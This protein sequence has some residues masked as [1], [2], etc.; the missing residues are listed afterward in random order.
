MKVYSYLRNYLTF[1]DYELCLEKL[2]LLRKRFTN[3]N[4][5]ISHYYFFYLFRIYKLSS[6]PSLSPFF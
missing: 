1:S 2:I 5:N 3:I 6:L 4:I